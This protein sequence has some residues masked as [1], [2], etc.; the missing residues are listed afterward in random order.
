M[1]ASPAI[2]APKRPTAIQPQPAAIWNAALSYERLGK[3]DE[4]LARYS[5]YIQLKNEPDA[6]FHAA[7]AEY[8]LGRLTA[9]AQR[10]HELSARPGLPTLQ[11]ASAMVQ[12]AVCR[13]QDQRIATCQ[14]L[15]A[16]VWRYCNWPC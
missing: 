16:N 9:A 7:L 4:A 11:K 5:K 14:M 10:L 1:A 15:R 8:K 2:P 12:E 3:L 13:G 6:Q